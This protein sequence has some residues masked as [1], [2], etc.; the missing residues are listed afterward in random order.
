MFNGFHT[1]GAA[2]WVAM[3]LFWIAFL[4]ATVWL[5]A[6]LAPSR[7]DHTSRRREDPQEILDRRLA[8]GEIDVPTYEQLREQLDPRPV[9]ETR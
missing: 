9:A 2:G 5:I 7:A 1:M 8:E 6:R 3:S 4:A